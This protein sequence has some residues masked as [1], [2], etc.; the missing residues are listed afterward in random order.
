M[1]GIFTNWIDINERKPEEGQRIIAYYP[2]CFCEVLTFGD[3]LNF[4]YWLPFTP[5]KKKRW[6]PKSID[7]RPAPA[8]HIRS[9][10]QVDGQ[11]RWCEADLNFLGLYPTKEDAEHMRDKLLAFLDK[12]IG[13]V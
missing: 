11:Y 2:E 3:N 5:P 13:E 10:G 7:G 9:D 4:T 1:S 12:E 6:R 8:W